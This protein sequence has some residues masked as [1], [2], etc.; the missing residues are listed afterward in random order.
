MFHQ[1]VCFHYLFPPCPLINISLDHVQLAQNLYLQKPPCELTVLMVSWAPRA[2]MWDIY[3][4]REMFLINIIP[5]TQLLTYV[6]QEH[7][8]KL[9]FPMPFK[10]Y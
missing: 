6:W 5:K 7:I 1:E 8:L 9:Y 3:A 4:N 2:N 10:S